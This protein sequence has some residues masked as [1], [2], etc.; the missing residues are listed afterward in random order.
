[1]QASVKGQHYG[2][3]VDISKYYN[4]YSTDCY[5]LVVFASL[6]LSTRTV[7]MASFAWWEGLTSCR[8]ELRYALEDAGEPSVTTS[9]MTMTPLL[10][11]SSS[12]LEEKVSEGVRV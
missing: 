3:F 1:M 4:Y 11:A 7:S 6:Q 8:G 9:G 5:T 2:A 10:L 12:A